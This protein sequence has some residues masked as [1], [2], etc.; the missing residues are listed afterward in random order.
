MS[1]ELQY[2]IKGERYITRADI[3]LHTTMSYFDTQRFLER[4]KPEIA[5]YTFGKVNYYKL[6][7]IITASSVVS[8]L[9]VLRQEAKMK[10]K[11][12]RESL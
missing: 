10:C 1:Q 6:T 7:D 5:S 9:K 2:Y 3:P 8:K 4:Y 12:V 11:L